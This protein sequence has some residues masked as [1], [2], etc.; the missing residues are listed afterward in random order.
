MNK[1]AWASLVIPLAIV[2]IIYFA[3]F[4]KTASF[5]APDLACRQT[6]DPTGCVWKGSNCL[7]SVVHTTYTLTDRNRETE[8]IEKG[9]AY[10]TAWISDR[11]AEGYSDCNWNSAF[12]EGGDTFAV[13]CCRIAPQSENNNN[14]IDFADGI[15]DKAGNSLWDIIKAWVLSLLGL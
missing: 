7:N 13:G 3:I 15:T 9:D 1:K 5:G 4:L 12:L 2:V 6:T 11:K 8:T 14:V 10:M